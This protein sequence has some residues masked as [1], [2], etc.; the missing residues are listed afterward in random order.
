MKN[1]AA[2]L[3]ALF[4]F[5]VISSPA[6]AQEAGKLYNAGLK[7][8]EFVYEYPDGDKETLTTAVWYPSE[9]KEEAY[10]Y[11]AAGER[12]SF[13]SKVAFDA[14][15]AK[16]GAPYPLIIFSHGLYGRGNGSAFF[17]DYLARNG[18]IVASA[19][20]TDTAPPDYQQQ[21]AFVRIKDG[22]IMPLAEGLLAAR[23]LA[24]HMNAVRP[25]LL[26]YLAKYRLKQP[27]FIL[28][29]MLQMNADP[30][31]FL[32]G[33]IDPAAIGMCG[34][35]LGGTTTLAKS[36]AYPAGEFKDGRIKA[37]LILSAPA[38]PFEDTASNIGIPV[39]FMAGDNDEPGLRPDIP[40]ITLFNKARPPKFYLV[41]L[42]A[43]H[44]S[45]TNSVCGDMDLSE[46]VS[47]IPQAV[48]IS[49]YGLA[50]FDRY[51]LN[52]LSAGKW[53]KESGPPLSKFTYHDIGRE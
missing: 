23:Q 44:Y 33:A 6:P 2:I 16:S 25:D 42:K 22:N 34:H 47:K 4:I 46:A 35:S 14:P 21:A 32:Y 49:Q 27:S 15:V 36:G 17:T 41:L 8:E 11:S 7:I 3:S 26:A 39:M 28:D 29:K 13:Q 9:G 20:Y 10:G 43:T 30:A 37:A 12:R 51:L 38:Y 1:P 52:D 24:D 40:R 48:A 19:D 50:F 53:I 5:S 45:F 18:Y 31:S